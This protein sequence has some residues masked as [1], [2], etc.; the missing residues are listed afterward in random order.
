MKGVEAVR[1]SVKK[2]MK[3]AYMKII[4]KLI[5]IKILCLT[6]T[7]IYAQEEEVKVTLEQILDLKPTSALVYWS[8]LGRIDQVEAILNSGLDPNMHDSDGYSALHAASENGHLEVVKILVEHDADIN[9]KSEYT[10]LELAKIAKK[11]EIVEY[12]IAHGAK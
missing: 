12:L 6:Y 7:L 8:S 9:Y 11:D 5:I 1:Y 4:L 10:A 3:F 2:W